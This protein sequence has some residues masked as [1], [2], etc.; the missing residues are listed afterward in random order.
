MMMTMHEHDD[1][2]GERRILSGG[3][4]GDVADETMATATMT[5]GIADESRALRSIECQQREV[6]FIVNMMS[7]MLSMWVC[8][9]IARGVD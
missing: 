8:E 1:D 5:T 3:E 6:H 9:A 4:I 7:L 2:G